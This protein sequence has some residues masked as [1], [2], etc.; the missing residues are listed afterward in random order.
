M[1]THR[2][3]SIR[4]TPDALCLSGLRINPRIPNHQSPI[5]NHQSP[6]TN[7]QSPITNHQPPTTNHQPPTTNHQTIRSGTPPAS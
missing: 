1:D 3:P 6:I 7:H 4:H 2:W 5:T